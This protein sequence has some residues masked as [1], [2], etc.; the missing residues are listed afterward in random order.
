MALTSLDP[1]TITRRP[2]PLGGMSPPMTG[3]PRYTTNVFN[4]GDGGD[5]SD[6]GGDGG[7]GSTP[8]PELAP[9]TGP[10]YTPPDPPPTLPTNPTTG[11]PTGN[12]P[13][14]PSGQGND[15]RSI[16]SGVFQQ[17]GLD[18]NNPGSG[19][20]NL[21]YFLGRAN[22]TNPNDT[23]Y[24]RDRLTQEIQQWQGHGTGSL[25][26]N[27][28]GGTNVFSDPATHQYEQLLNSLIQRFM[29]P[30]TP[31]DYG[32]ALN[33][34]NEYFKQLQGPAYTPQQMDLMTTQV[35]DPI[36]QQ[37]DQSRQ[38]ILA[39][40]GGQGMGPNSGPVQQALLQNDQY[41][42]SLGTTAR[43][44]VANNAIG[45]QKQQQAQAASLG[46]QI[47]NMELQNYNQQNQNA[48]QAAS[49]AGIIPNMAYSRLLGANGAI[50]S[51][52][53]ASLLGPLYA[54]QQ[55]GYNQSSD[56]YTQLFQAL[57]HAMGLA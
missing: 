39:R 8:A 29:T 54:F 4:Q 36:Q 47:A 43:A 53:P 35:Y 3:S 15:L 50:Q 17:F 14:P 46:P 6:T 48:L 30:Y 11:V 25:I 56:F 57:A 24:W 37:R 22:A 1:S 23:N 20:G 27:E 55:Q 52:N 21:D 40:F 5:G 19:L 9:P 45:V 28:Y 2:P 34:L 26:P 42:N 38:Q 33:Y 18:P 13:T 31:P 41:Y 10:G 51:L 16:L 12:T 32:N 7:D 44:N 49:L